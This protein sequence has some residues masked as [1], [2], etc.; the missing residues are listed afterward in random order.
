MS[1]LSCQYLKPAQK[2]GRRARAIRQ[3]GDRPSQSEYPSTEPE[4]YL[5]SGTQATISPASI[6]NASDL[7]HSPASSLQS[8]ATPWFSQSP[9]AVGNQHG[10]IVAQIQAVHDELLLSLGSYAPELSLDN[11]VSSCINIFMRDV[12]PNSFMVDEN[13]IRSNIPLQAPLVAE[14]ILTFSSSAG[15]THHLPS[16][17][18]LLPKLRLYALT[19][20]ICASASYMLSLD[21]ATKTGELGAIFLRASRQTLELYQHLDLANPDSASVVVRTLIAAALHTESKFHLAAQVQL[22]AVELARRM[23]FYK[24]SSLAGLH[25]TEAQIRRNLFWQI[26]VTDKYAALVEGRPMVLHELCLGEPFT[27]KMQ[28]DSTVRLMTVEFGLETS[29]IEEHLYSGLLLYQRLW[30]AATEIALD[31]Q[32]LLRQH[33][34]KDNAKILEQAQDSNI[35]SSYLDFISVVDSLLPLSEHFERTVPEKE[36]ATNVSWRQ[37]SVQRTNILVSYH[38]LKMIL[39]QRFVDVGIGSL[40]GLGDTDVMLGL[41]KTDI[42][43]DLITV[44]TTVPFESLKANGERCVSRTEDML[45]P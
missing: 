23:C 33:K 26:Y 19:T 38:C 30:Y 40:L 22:E 5:G 42:A 15:L 9:H 25:P 11:I 32:I 18:D 24:E 29:Q 10:S 2:R 28:L 17:V 3:P 31:L 7:I 6:D 36:R 20:A 35:M 39:L 27:V 21:M 16:V 1:R 37:F 4:Y 34:R 12:F 45:V 8:A 14:N 43:H 41:R 13:Q 44:I